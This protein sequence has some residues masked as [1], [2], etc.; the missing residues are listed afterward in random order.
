MEEFISEIEGIKAE[1]EHHPEGLSITDLANQLGINRNSVAKYLEILQIQGSVDGKKRGT[2]KV[3]YISHRV[4]AFSIRKVCTRP[5]LLLNHEG[6][7]VDASPQFFPVTGL[8]PGHVLN[9]PFEK[10]PL[11][12]LEGDNA[13]QI[14]RAALKGVE[15][16]VHA[17]IFQGNQSR[18]VSLFL[19]PVV[20]ETGKPG[21]SV[22]LDEE[23][24]V[25][26]NGSSGEPLLTELRT[27]LDNQIEYVVQYT[28]DG[29]IRFANEPYCHAIGRS[30]EDL[31]GHHFKPL[32]TPDDA[33][34]IR[35]HRSRLSIR[36]PTGMIEFR[37]IMA[38]GEARWQRWWDRAVFDERGQ[39]S[40]YYSCG[41][42]NTDLVHANQKLKKT[43]EML[44]ET[45][46][47]RTN[48]LRGIN[49]QLYEEMARREKM[50]QQFQ[51]TQ[52]AMD[53]AADLVF[54]VNRNARIDYANKAA[55]ASLGYEDSDVSSFLF[56][57][58]FSI[59][60]QKSWG[61]LWEQLRMEGT[62]T[63]KAGMIK[64]DGTSVPVEMVIR[65]MEYHGSEFACCFSRDISERARMEQAI[66][67][68]NKKLNILTSLARHDIQN[69][70]T[71]LLGFL[72]R[73]RKKEKDPVILGY[74]DRQELAAKAIRD[75]ITL[76]RD[77]K[78]LGSNPP[79]W[80]TLAG[81]ITHVAES[82]A[83]RPVS[84]SVDLPEV[85][86]YADPQIG[87]VFSRL[88]DNAL[89][90]NPAPAAIRI[91]SR[92]DDIGL[93]IVLDYSSAGISPDQ[94]ETLFA[95]GSEGFGQN[96]LYI[97]REILSLTGISIH[98]SGIF[99]Q[100]TRFEIT[101]PPSSYRKIFLKH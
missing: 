84:F 5:H 81:I 4:P 39:L 79:E 37:A 91:N 43:Q 68:A 48:E 10:L 45:I 58:I 89:S 99:G 3:F 33:E 12:I 55:V 95:M 60:L 83:Q 63:C 97:V 15:Q 2:S 25:S 78:D 76:T 94:K 73:I 49:Q 14:L 85:S 82:Y 69:K 66:Q 96:G 16:H 44:E 21:V 87:R 93:V 71:V 41:I 53:N 62:L 40:G 74:L 64:N 75:E 34:R 1:L 26:G 23:N 54:W 80:L 100:N 72:G 38:N 24:A 22:I 67:L 36:Y 7:I 61:D 17:Q 46:V 90:G 52:F 29:I 11:K 42:D 57:D 65:F 9:Q 31:I 32:V 101:V 50:E 30:R 51:R 70:I 59:S 35:V 77:F 28:P 88:F 92:E 47:A 27:L 56:G 98:E 8:E 20:F 13:Q 6:Q 18:Y 86:L 19:I